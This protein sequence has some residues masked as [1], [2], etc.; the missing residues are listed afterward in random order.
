MKDEIMKKKVHVIVDAYF[1]GGKIVDSYKKKLKDNFEVAIVHVQSTSVP[2]N[3]MPAIAFEKYDEN[4]VCTGDIQKVIDSLNE[5]YE[6]IAVLLGHESGVEL[7]DTLSE[8]FG[9]KSSNGTEKSVARRNKYEMIKTVAEAGL[10]TPKFIKSNNLSEI[11][12]WAQEYPIVIKALRS[13]GT[14]GVYICRNKEELKIA[15]QKLLGS[16]SI[17]DEINEEILVES[18]LQGKEYVVN[19]VSKD[20]KHYV[21]DVG[22]YEKKLIPGHATIYD[23]VMLLPSHLPEVKELINYNAKVLDALDINNGPSHA[24]I[25][26]TPEQG[27]VLVEVGVRISGAINSTFCNLCLGHNQL[28]L[29]VDCYLDTEKFIE[30]VSNLPYTLKQHGMIIDLIY[31]GLPGKL[32]RVNESVLAKIKSLKSVVEVVIKLHEGDTISPTRTLLSSPA[33]LFLGHMNEQQL[34]ED[35]NYIEEMK[36]RLFIVNSQR[37]HR[38][39]SLIEDKNTAVDQAEIVVKSNKYSL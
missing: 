6:V 35:Y 9:L 17:Y 21:T 11:L 1:S 4:I 19:A 29:T 22:I 8:R 26:L 33:R 39:P 20:R 24:E 18:F 25:F 31:E 38:H 5:K 12:S 13:A 23:K 37:F 14:D 10:A 2:A 36:G 15:F 34:Y 3:K 7:A 27:P 32:E 16:K 30:T 28:D